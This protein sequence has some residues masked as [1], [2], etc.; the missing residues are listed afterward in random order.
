M[1]WIAEPFDAEE[2]QH[3]FRT[4]TFRTLQVYGPLSIASDL[5]ALQSSVQQKYGTTTANFGPRYLHSTG[6]LHKGGPKNIAALQIIL[7]PTSKDVVIPGSTPESTFQDLHMA[8]AASDFK[9]MKD[10]GR[11]VAQLIVD[12]L[13]EVARVL[14]L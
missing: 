13:N 4:A 6:Q 9:A 2:L 8:Q 5:S 14:G 10:S 7:R 3:D 1:Q 11:H 12:D